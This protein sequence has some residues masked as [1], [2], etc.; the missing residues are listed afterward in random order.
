MGVCFSRTFS[1]CL[2]FECCAQQ[3]VSRYK[4]YNSGF[5]CRN[6]DFDSFK[7]DL[8]AKSLFG[9]VVVGSGL[10]ERS[11]APAAIVNYSCQSISA[12]GVEI[13]EKEALSND[14]HKSDVTPAFNASTSGACEPV[15]PHT[16][17]NV[18]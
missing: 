3:I 4:R 18:L 14:L 8:I 7:N 13:F 16:S 1:R 10:L 11:T 5:N 6:I 2:I 12:I 15:N 9:E 17:S